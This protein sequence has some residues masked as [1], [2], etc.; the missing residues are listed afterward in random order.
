MPNYRRPFVP[1]GTFFFTVTTNDRQPVLTQPSMLA[2]LRDAVRQTRRA[3]PFDIVAW[4]V[5]PDHLHAIWALPPGDANFSLRWARIKQFVTRVYAE[6]PFAVKVRSPS[7][8]KRREGTLLATTLLGTPNSRRNR[9]CAAYR[10][11]PLQPGETRPRGTSAGLA[12]FYFSQIRT[13]GY[14]FS[15]LGG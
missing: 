3:L 13:V 6:L 10:I 11:Y 9:S 1:G 8:A 2:A 7:R 5:V 12:A 4:V 15:A 14:L